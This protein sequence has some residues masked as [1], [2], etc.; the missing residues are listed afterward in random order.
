MTTMATPLAT[1]GLERRLEP[2][3]GTHTRALDAAFA[4]LV[5][6]QPT[7]PATDVEH[8]SRQASLALA[9][10]LL[11]R[12]EIR[13]PPSAIR[14][15]LL[16]LAEGL[17]AELPRI[18]PADAAAMLAGLFERAVGESGRRDLGA[19]YTPPDVVDFMAREAIA[20]RLADGLQLSTESARGMLDGDLQGLTGSQ[21]AAAGALLSGL[22]L[23]DPA[24][25][26][27]AFLVGAAIRLAQFAGRLHEIGVPGMRGIG[28][29]AGALRGC[30]RG[31]ELD[32]DAVTIANAVLTL[33]THRAGTSTPCAI[34][35]QRNPLLQGMKHP[36]ARAGWD[37]VLMNPPYIGEKHV[38]KRLGD[39]LSDALRERD[40]FA[41]DLL[42]HFMHR[43]LS[44]VREGGV[45][46]A[47]VSDTAFTMETATELRRE[48]LD[49]S[50]LLSVA[51]CRP[52][53]TVAVQ[54]GVITVLRR[55]PR[56]RTPVDW[57][58]APARASLATAPRHRTPRRLYR[59]LPG[60]QLYRPSPAARAIAEK[61]TSIDSL[62]ERWREVGRRASKQDLARELPP[63]G[64][65]TLLGCV[66]RGGQGLATGDDRRFVGT[67][68][69]TLA[70]AR[71]GESQ[72]KIL[73]ALRTDPSRRRE[74]D[75]LRARLGSGLQLGDALVELSD[76]G[77]IGE[78]P[79]RKPFLVI[80]PAAVRSA[81]LTASE[82][83]LG[84]T[85]GPSW[86]PYETSDR[87]SSGGGARWVRDNQTVIDWSSEA[88]ALLRHRLLAGPRRPVLRNEDLWFQGGVTHNRIASYLRARMM[89]PQAIFSSESPVYVPLVRWLSPHGLLALLNAPVVEF[90]LKTF[91]A[92]RNHI[93]VGH[94]RR[95]P[96]PVLRAPQSRRLTRLGESAIKAAQTDPT[97]LPDVE[98]EIDCFTRELYGVG[99]VGLEL[100]R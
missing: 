87:S 88:V 43:A 3:E 89:P 82:I 8:R 10:A 24:V 46:S 6:T 61:W 53:R 19:V 41:G 48:L 11:G 44:G 4:T 26:A 75:L 22:R 79:G 32:G 25:G 7:V 15:P 58:D 34:V 17:V 27:G 80:D 68:A 85:D 2:A 14:K 60:R 59:R 97:S 47:I 69:G 90:A 20:A 38:R 37:V 39:G 83:E 62:D 73:D 93:E 1:R 84:I 52:F 63:K 86:V 40:G 42:A 21:V 56:A 5:A 74:W 55:A 18:D 51:W 54:G 76:G 65:W 99:A 57:L 23:V 50:L 70:A 12:F 67:L 71:A 78:L 33:T 28:T 31:Y 30:C 81:P 35:T 13:Q 66:V 94:V 49:R 92:T 9:S 100:T 77:Q 72:R 96:I 64:H 95:L 98:A 91:L 45:V 16:R 29:P 36:S